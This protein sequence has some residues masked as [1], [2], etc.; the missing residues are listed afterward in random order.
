M[1]TYLDLHLRTRCGEYLALLNTFS[2]PSYPLIRASAPT[3]SLL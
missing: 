1:P 3:V 2:I